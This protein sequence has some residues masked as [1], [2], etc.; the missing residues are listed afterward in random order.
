[1]AGVIK[2]T[3]HHLAP[4]RVG[5]GLHMA[6]S[7]Q[8]Q[9]PWRRCVLVQADAV[10]HWYQGVVDAMEEQFGWAAQALDRT[11]R[12][13]TIG[14][15]PGQWHLQG[16]GQPRCT[17]RKAPDITVTGR[18]TIEHQ[19]AEALALL[20]VG[21]QVV[22]GHCP[23]QALPQQY[24]GF[25]LDFRGLVEPCHGRCDVIVDLWQAGLALGQAIAPVI[26]HQHLIALLRQPVATA[27]VT[28][29][30]AAI[31]VQVQYRALDLD[32]RLGRQPPAMQADAVGGGQGD[33]VVLQLGT[34]GRERLARFRVE[35]QAAA[36][37]QA[38]QRQTQCQAAAA[39]KEYSRSRLQ[40]D[41]GSGG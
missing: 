24:Q 10:V 3:Q 11:D 30:I 38:Q 7:S 5:K 1:M 16:P 6:A 32:T 12:A 26:D 17:Q 4:D 35:Q 37:A 27:Q 22:D 13:V 41:P 28:G 19:G 33:I 29:Q 2:K 8:L 40:C 34:L 23:A 15:Q 20:G 31:A 21:C 36:P 25:A 9:H 18:H 14:Y 39:L